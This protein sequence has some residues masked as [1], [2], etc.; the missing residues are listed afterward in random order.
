MKLDRQQGAKLMEDYEG[1]NEEL[2]FD[3]RK[4]R[5]VSDCKENKAKYFQR[6]K[7][8]AKI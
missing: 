7:S 6:I 5:K 8:T 4:N 2:K 3:L 1:Q